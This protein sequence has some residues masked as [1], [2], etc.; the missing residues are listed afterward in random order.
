MRPTT[1]AAIATL[2]AGLRGNVTRAA[3]DEITTKGLGVL[4][5]DGWIS[6]LIHIVIHHLAVAAYGFYA[7]IYPQIIHEFLVRKGR[8]GVVEEE[9]ARGLLDYFG[10]RTSLSSLL[11]WIGKE[12]IIVP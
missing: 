11:G 1:A 3:H 10:S 8:V 7:Q 5:L 12:H 9:A 2:K 4:F 6:A